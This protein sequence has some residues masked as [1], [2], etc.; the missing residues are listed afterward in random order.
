MFFLLKA[1]FFLKLFLQK[2]RKILLLLRLSL[3]YLLLHFLIVS[4]SDTLLRLRWLPPGGFLPP[5]VDLSFLHPDKYYAV[6]WGRA[7]ELYFWEKPF[8]LSFQKEEEPLNSYFIYASASEQKRDLDRQLFYLRLDDGRLAEVSTGIGDPSYG[9][10]DLY[11]SVQFF[12][13]Y[14]SNFYNKYRITHHKNTCILQGHFK[15]PFI[16]RDG[17]F[18]PLLPPRTDLYGFEEVIFLKKWSLERGVEDVILD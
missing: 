5:I 12:K 10:E 11:L 14:E 8:L 15:T 16:L 7:Y 6:S 1:I 13:E 18:K 17:K 2:H 9:K 3:I 4:N